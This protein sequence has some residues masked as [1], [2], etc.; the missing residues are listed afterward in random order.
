MRRTLATIL[1]ACPISLPGQTQGAPVATNA[2]PTWA[3]GQEWRLSAIPT[4]DIGSAFAG[5]E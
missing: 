3:N 2:R 1:L 5:P 4:V